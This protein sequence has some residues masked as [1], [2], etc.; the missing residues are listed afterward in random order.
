MYSLYACEN[1]D[2]S[3]QP[4]KTVCKCFSFPFLS[5]LITQWLATL[6]RLLMADIGCCY[7]LPLCTVC[8]MCSIGGLAGTCSCI[9][10]KGGH[11]FSCRDDL[12]I[13][14]SVQK[15]FMFYCFPSLDAVFCFLPCLLIQSDLD[16]ILGTYWLS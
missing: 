16:V 6:S 8:Y 3:G 15:K 10:L 5:S 12:V 2:N 13:H 11:S 1:D 4:L 7:L 9:P 14:R